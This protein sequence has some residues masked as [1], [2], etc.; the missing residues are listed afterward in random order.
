MPGDI[1]ERW[2]RTE[3]DPWQHPSFSPLPAI[4]T[5]ARARDIV[6][7]FDFTSRF[8]IPSQRLHLGLGL[9]ALLL[10]ISVAGC[11]GIDG[12]EPTPTTRSALPS[13][14]ESVPPSGPTAL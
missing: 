14:T 10:A 4:Y 8:A 11:F 2:L 7:D 12:V 5:S 3:S 1:G 6:A 13:L 9:A